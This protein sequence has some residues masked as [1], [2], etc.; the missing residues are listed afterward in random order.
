MF[1]DLPRRPTLPSRTFVKVTVLL[2]NMISNKLEEKAGV[3]G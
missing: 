2:G 3:Y 1:D